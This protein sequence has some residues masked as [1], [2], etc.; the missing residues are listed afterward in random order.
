MAKDASLY[1]IV[2]YLQNNGKDPY[3]GL[4]SQQQQYINQHLSDPNAPGDIVN[5]LRGN[6]RDMFDSRGQMYPD[7]FNPPGTPP[8]T[9]TPKLPDRETP[10][11]NIP[12][13]GTGQPVNPN[14]AVP[15]NDLSK[16]IDGD[17]RQLQS[18]PVDDD[19]I[20]EFKP[21][22]DAIM[23]AQD[24][25]PHW[26]NN[27][28]GGIDK[29]KSGLEHARDALVGHA[30]GDAV[31][32][33]FDNLNASL[34]VL[35]SLKN[36][37]TTLESL[38]KHFFED[39]TTT[40]QN[41]RQNESAYN[42]AINKKNPDT[43]TIKKLNA[44]AQQYMDQYRGPI[45]DIASRHPTVDDALLATGMPG[46]APVHASG[47]PGGPGGGSPMGLTQSGL[48]TGTPEAGT[49]S[50][51]AG[52]APSMP[53]APTGAAKGAADAAKKAGD[54]AQ[55][56]L[57]QAGKAAAKGLTDT[58]KGAGKGPGGLPEGV[59]GLGSKSVH[60]AGKSGGGVGGRGGGGRG[61][62][63][64]ARPPAKLAPASKIGPAATPVSRAGLSGTGGQGGTG[65]PAAGHRGGGADKTHKA[66]KALH[67]AKNGEELLGEV[68]AVTPVLG[69]QP[70]KAAPKRPEA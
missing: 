8:F 56:G 32:A 33:M 59:L 46:P 43:D 50:A 57:G 10:P 18:R 9:P 31:Q 61:A 23:T 11:A 12:G 3:A 34:P 15:R 63:T 47:V 51:K 35:D 19:G 65:A 30:S 52:A 38:V 41:F 27:W 17:G 16:E 39:I 44:Y 2:A 1:E 21:G 54:G 25:F 14:V 22:L 13:P 45:D 36:H 42:D 69:G 55:K 29:I 37:A 67:A 58:L 40:K 66:N 24:G 49:Q 70:Q 60:G 26:P 48:N 7:K 62:G 53:K 6:H 20:H 4:T 68:D 5:V 64:G 28:G